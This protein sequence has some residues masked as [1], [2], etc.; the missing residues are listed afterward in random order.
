MRRHCDLAHVGKATKNKILS[1]LRAKTPF[2]CQR[3]GVTALCDFPKSTACSARF[4]K[5]VEQ[6]KES[7][8]WIDKPKT[9]STLLLENTCCKR[10][11]PGK[12]TAFSHP[13]KIDA[14]I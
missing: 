8:K 2:G 12:K 9:Y 4:P 14:D 5:N 7:N 3:P 10:I 1:R 6:T 13:K 11:L